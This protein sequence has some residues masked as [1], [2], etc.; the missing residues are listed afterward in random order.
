MG[1]L[2]PAENAEVKA[3]RLAYPLHEL[4]PIP[5]LP[6]GTGSDRQYT[7]D[8]VALTQPLE[9]PE[10]SDHTFHRFGAE[11]I[12]VPHAFA[13]ADLL[14]D[15]VNQPKRGARGIGEYDQAARVRADIDHPDLADGRLASRKRQRDAGILLGGDG[16]KQTPI[17]VETP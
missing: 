13:E 17:H 7:I 3:R 10:E 16:A 5:G 1:L 6:D 2:F 9:D 4:S 14:A 12:L 8:A 15:L 11:E